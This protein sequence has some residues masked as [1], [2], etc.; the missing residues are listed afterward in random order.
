MGGTV[1][2]GTF[3]TIDETGRLVVRG[4][5]GV[6]HVISAGDVHFGVAATAER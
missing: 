5:E 4:A 2:R 1:F 6:A 3:E